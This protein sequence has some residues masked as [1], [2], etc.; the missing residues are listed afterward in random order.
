[1]PWPERMS[2]I[3]SQGKDKPARCIC[4]AVASIQSALGL[5]SFVFERVFFHIIILLSETENRCN[6][7]PPLIKLSQCLHYRANVCAHYNIVQLHC[8]FITN[9]PTLS[10]NCS[11]AAQTE[12]QKETESHVTAGEYQPLNQDRSKI[13][14]PLNRW[15]TFIHQSTSFPFHFR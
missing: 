12:T 8:A 2:E 13:K 3:C 9:T 11:A 6:R 14:R 5:Y 10:H 15:H 4:F 1:M 7:I